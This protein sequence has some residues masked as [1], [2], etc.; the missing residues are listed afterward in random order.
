MPKIEGKCLRLNYVSNTW[1]HVKV[2]FIP[3]SIVEVAVESVGSDLHQ[4]VF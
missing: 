2:V 4:V 1:K 3:K